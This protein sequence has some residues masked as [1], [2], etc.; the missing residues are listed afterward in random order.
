MGKPEVIHL[1]R[2]HVGDTED[3][4]QQKKSQQGRNS[5]ACGNVVKPDAYKQYKGTDEQNESYHNIQN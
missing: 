3:S 5:Q 2:N 1:E 4:A